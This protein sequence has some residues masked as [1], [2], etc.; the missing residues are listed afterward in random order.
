MHRAPRTAASIEGCSI[1]F[2]LFPCPPIFPPDTIY[3]VNEWGI[4]L[5]FAERGLGQS[6]L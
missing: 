4:A 5:S 1:L 6:K 2:W 3:E